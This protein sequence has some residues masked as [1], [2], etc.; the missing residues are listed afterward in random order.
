MQRYLLALIIASAP[1]IAGRPV[2]AQGLD[3]VVTVSNRTYSGEITEATR[4]E[5]TVS[6]RAGDR[7]IKVSEIKTV[8][9]RD[10][11]TELRSARLA[12]QRGAYAQARDELSRIATSSVSNK[13]VREDL[14][15]YLAWCE[16]KLALTGGDKNKA[17]QL[18]RAFESKY[19]QSFHYYEV[20]RLLGELAIVVGRA[21]VAAAY[22]EKLASAPFPEYQM[23]AH[24]LSGDA[25]RAQGKPQEALTRYEK[26]LAQTLDSAEANRQKLFAK[27]GKA[28][29]LAEMGQAEQAVQIV[30]EVI[31]TTPSRTHPR[32]FGRAYN[33]LGDA[34]RKLG[35]PKEALLA[36]LHTD[37]LY[38]H[39]PTVHAEALYHL[40]TLW[41]EAVKNPDRA[42]QAE[43][44]LRTSYG[45][46]LWGKRLAESGEGR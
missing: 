22:F 1:A 10:D 20:V 34:Y 24:M 23:E 2:L 39:D 46:T 12:A 41:R 7:K 32:L 29:C 42:M 8:M 30:Q 26:I 36:Y 4:N 5:V 3:R 15:F 38:P 21:D 40:R 28:A 27:V 31:K 6:T 14:E 11:P 19:P 18:L 44:L 37:L 45:G 17:V 35:K 13:L 16:G 33:A 25:L 9:F 43:N